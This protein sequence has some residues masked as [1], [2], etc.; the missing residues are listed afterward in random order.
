MAELAEAFRCAAH[1][2][3]TYH[4]Y[5][6]AGRRKALAAVE[7]VEHE[8]WGM[9]YYLCPSCEGTKPTHKLA[10]RLAAELEE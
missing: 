6:S 5:R 9:F 10:C 7:W 3:E 2:A 8:G 4:A 1:T